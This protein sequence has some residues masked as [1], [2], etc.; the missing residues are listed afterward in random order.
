MPA[1]P[2]VSSES[3]QPDPV[4]AAHVL[5]N[6]PSQIRHPKCLWRKDPA[7]F[8]MT[9][10]PLPQVPEIHRIVARASYR[11]RSH[12][13]LLPKTEISPAFT[14]SQGPSRSNP[15]HILQN[16]IQQLSGQKSP[17]SLV[18][19]ARHSRLKHVRF[20]PRRKGVSHSYHFILQSGT[21]PKT[22]VRRSSS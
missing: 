17:H 22:N 11:I 16:T 6:H 13:P 7:L 14:M 15:V 3:Q 4:R 2:S 5:Q 20:E 9:M 1:C 10:K 19:P 18:L 12:L 21:K 8:H